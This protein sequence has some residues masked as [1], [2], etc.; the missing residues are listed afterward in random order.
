LHGLTHSLAHCPV[1]GVHRPDLKVYIQVK[2]KDG[3]DYYDVEGVEQLHKISRLESNV[4][5]VLV[6]T[7]EDFSESTKAIASEHDVILINGSE[8]IEMMAKHL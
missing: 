3:L 8:I 2:Q 5:K 6:S 1:F 4:Q 7:A